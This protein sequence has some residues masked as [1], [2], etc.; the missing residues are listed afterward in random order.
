MWNYIAPDKTFPFWRE[1]DPK[2]M[3]YNVEGEV[4]LLAGAPDR[5]GR[6]SDS[7]GDANS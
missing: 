1:A 4:D 2:F 6:G 7:A 5:I 3:F